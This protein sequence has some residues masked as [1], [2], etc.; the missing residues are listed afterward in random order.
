MPAVPA[1]PAAPLPSSIYDDDI[2]LGLGDWLRV[3]SLP[4][5]L[6]RLPLSNRDVW[7]EV[8]ARQDFADD[9]RREHVIRARFSMMIGALPA[10]LIIVSGISLTAQLELIQRLALA[11]M[12]GT[13]DSRQIASYRALGDGS[14]GD[15]VH[16][17]RTR[18]GAASMPASERVKRILGEH[19]ATEQRRRSA[20]VAHSADAGGGGS[21]ASAGVAGGGGDTATA[22]AFLKVNSAALERFVAANSAKFLA[23]VNTPE[24]SAFAAAGSAGP[25]ADRD[26]KRILRI[27]FRREWGVAYLQF[28][29]T[30]RPCGNE[31]F[32]CMFPFKH[33][34]YSYVSAS[35]FQNYDGT[36]DDDLEAVQ[37]H[38]V[39]D[40]RTG[41][42]IGD[43]V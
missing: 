39:R 26:A 21:S 30:T 11:L 12:P 40:T 2:R 35:V 31:M 24:S 16:V 23:D 25:L 27:A 7:L 14:A 20:P 33:H 43:Y 38:Y 36:L 22:P 37:A 4:I 19:L 10:L 5:E 29:Q 18:G 1:V 3:L 34:L 9:A 32:D 28:T 8:Q 15:Y 41:R 17:L 6:F 13:F 42:S